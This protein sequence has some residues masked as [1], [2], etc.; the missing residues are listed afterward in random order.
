MMQQRKQKG[1]KSKRE[2]VKESKDDNPVKSRGRSFSLGTKGFRSARSRSNSV[3][4]DEKSAPSPSTLRKTPTNSTASTSK[5]SQATRRPSGEVVAVTRS[6]R[7]PL[8]R[9]LSY[10]S[11][12]SSNDGKSKSSQANDRKEINFVR[13][14]FPPSKGF[15]P[16]K[17]VDFFSKP[18]VLSRLIQGQKF[19][20]AINRLEKHGPAE[21][22]IWVCTKR[23]LPSSLQFAE[24]KNSVTNESSCSLS[25]TSK[26]SF[27]SKSSSASRMA[28]GAKSSKLKM[29]EDEKTKT[30][31]SQFTFR[32][33]PIHMACGSLF[34][35]EDQ[36]IRQD[37]EQL[38]ARLVIAYPDGCARRDHQGR[39]PLHECVWYNAAPAI[40][41]ALL[42]AAPEIA[43]IADRQGVTPM[44][45]NE[46]R[47][48]PNPTHKNMIRGMLK[49]SPDFW[50]AAR[51]EADLRMKHR[52]IPS[53]DATITS[54]SV[55]ASSDMEDETIDSKEKQY[56][57]QVQPPQRQ[58]RQQ[59][60]EQQ[61]EQRQQLL[62]E[63]WQLPPESQPEPVKPLEWSQLEKKALALEQKLAESYEYIYVLNQQ[64][65]EVKGAKN[66]LQIKVDKFAN[67]DLGKQVVALE[68]EKDEL[69]FHLARSQALL[70]KHGISL[71][72]ENAAEGMP[73]LPP[74]QI[75]FESTPTEPT[76]AITSDEEYEIADHEENDEK[77]RLE[78]EQEKLAQLREQLNVLNQDQARY[79]ERLQY[80]GEEATAKGEIACDDLTAMTPAS[81]VKP[82]RPEPDGNTSLVGG[83]AGRSNGPRMAALAEDRVSGIDP[84]TVPSIG[85]TNEDVGMMNG[86]STHSELDSV[87]AGA[88]EL[89]GGEGLSPD[90]I[91]LWKATSIRSS[92]GSTGSK[93]ISGDKSE[94]NDVCN[95]SSLGDDYDLEQQMMA[96]IRARPGA[97]DSSLVSA[98]KKR[99]LVGRTPPRKV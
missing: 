97:D 77:A 85:M 31:E 46:H 60:Q 82:H 84:P 33:L 39:Y 54:T 66:A 52:E 67:S 24:I 72:E 13:P 1:V 78:R 17:E 93:P 79:Q 55:L 35:V 56:P 88:M 80:L 37:L 28:N 48:C 53:A 73:P 30:S 99:H 20:A 38:I 51:K 15:V 6:G 50:R 98:P 87:L 47:K 8:R 27:T 91:A 11:S 2:T 95:V 86:G 69:Q 94:S 64:L 83:V 4:R 68:E 41:S 44:A 3:N 70:A 9:S 49:K 58:Q 7:G 22:S 21:A 71:E 18:T 59:R 40:V 62:Q 92:I 23:K 63:I 16:D 96:V 34:R 36:T 74:L 81:R 29:T 57:R 32:Q 75:S 65:N 26:S 89:N 19:A 14:S 43:K 76:A 61:Q 42:M 45:L 10:T 90:M 25:S 12:S 5:K